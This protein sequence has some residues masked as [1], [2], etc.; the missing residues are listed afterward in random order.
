MVAGRTVHQNRP[1][2]FSRL[3]VL[4]WD[5][6]KIRVVNMPTIREKALRL[7]APPKFSSGTSPDNGRQAPADVTDPAAGRKAVARRLTAIVED[8]PRRAEELRWRLVLEAAPVGLIIANNVGE[9]LDANQ[10]A[11]E[12]FGVARSEDVIGTALDTCV[13]AEDSKVLAGFVLRVC[14]G[15][16]GALECHCVGS[17][18][19]RRLVEIRAVPL[20]RAGTTVFL[21]VMWDVSESRKTLS[22]RPAGGSGE[23]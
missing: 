4:V 11:L 15:V 7:L 23:E 10:S 17:D 14:G 19:T 9:V 18:G 16:S 3:C 1:H 13:A 12:S 22:R 6:P 21:G 2:V 5:M 8:L 20:Q